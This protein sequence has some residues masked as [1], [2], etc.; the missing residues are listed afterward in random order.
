MR[1]FRI[2]PGSQRVEQLLS[3]ALSRRREV[4]M[5][6]LRG[7]HRQEIHAHQA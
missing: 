5:R 7:A 1:A 2:V 6:L 3:I 4:F